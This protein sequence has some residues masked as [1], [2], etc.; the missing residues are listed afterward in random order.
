MRKKKRPTE[1]GRQDADSK[2]LG[3]SGAGVNDDWTKGT[4]C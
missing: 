3:L 2:R 4:L 1:T